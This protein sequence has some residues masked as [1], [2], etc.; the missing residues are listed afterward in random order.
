MKNIL[1]V[2]HQQSKGTLF[3]EVE[4]VDLVDGVLVV[5]RT[6]DRILYVK[7]WAGAE[8]VEVAKKGP[9]AAREELE[10]GL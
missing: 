2:E 3:D 4:Q 8:V 10:V 5:R 1:I 9:I 7:E 6:G